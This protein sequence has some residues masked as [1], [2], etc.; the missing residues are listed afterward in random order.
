MY[1][2]KWVICDGIRE[3]CSCETRLS[4]DGKLHVVDFLVDTLNE[5]KDEVDNFLLF[6]LQEVLISYQ[7]AVVVAINRFFA[8]DLKFVSTQREKTIQHVG[9]QNFNLLIFLDANADT[10]GVDRS[11][12]QGLFLL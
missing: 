12:D 6:V 10:H 4:D 3:I 1:I 7:K 2:S 9:E 11:L 8:Q 5:F